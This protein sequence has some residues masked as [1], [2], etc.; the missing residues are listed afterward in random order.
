MRHVTHALCGLV[1]IA[2]LAA[3][4][5]TVQE[6]AL[7]GGV[8]GAGAGAVGAALVDG[9]VVGGALIGGAAGAAAGGLTNREQ[10]DIGDSPF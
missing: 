3:C 2:T 4:G 9:N 8:I 5:N 10:I 7:T 1:V 6:R